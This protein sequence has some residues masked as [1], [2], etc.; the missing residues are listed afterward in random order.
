MSVGVGSAKGWG[1]V[2][3]GG[4]ASALGWLSRSAT[5]PV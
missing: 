1:D 4:G 3:M 5:V 2:V